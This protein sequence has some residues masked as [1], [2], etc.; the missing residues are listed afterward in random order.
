MEADSEVNEHVMITA[1]K[2]HIPADA[3]VFSGSVSMPGGS[4]PTSKMPPRAKGIAPVFSLDADRCCCDSLRLLEIQPPLDGSSYERND[5]L[6]NW[7]EDLSSQGECA[8]ARLSCMPHRHG[9][10]KGGTSQ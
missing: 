6:D 10:L 9:I 8:I 7:M 2:R 1:C 4:K 5:E 3:R